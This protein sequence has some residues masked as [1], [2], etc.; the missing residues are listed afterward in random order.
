M[1]THEF[2]AFLRQ[3]RA[4]EIRKGDDA[5]AHVVRVEKRTGLRCDAWQLRDAMIATDK[6]MQMRR[7]KGKQ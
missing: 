5:E 3:L 4:A 7:T 6:R 2:P 1:K